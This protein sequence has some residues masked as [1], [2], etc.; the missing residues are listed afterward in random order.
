MNGE[1]GASTG[2]MR[3][4]HVKAKQAGE[5]HEHIRDRGCRLFG[6]HS[7]TE[8]TSDQARQ[9]INDYDELISPPAPVAV[10]GRGTSFGSLPKFVNKKVAA[11]PAKPLQ[12]AQIA[13]A[14]VVLR[15]G[16][17]RIGTPPG[18]G[19]PSP[20]AH[21]SFLMKKKP[22]HNFDANLKIARDGVEEIPW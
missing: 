9:L 18:H 3:L 21:P 7:L 2:Q 16:V 19:G 5:D 15:N 14:P 22:V 20:A 11:A 4:L 10:L 13:A 1:M 17:P 12:S 8:L 6:I